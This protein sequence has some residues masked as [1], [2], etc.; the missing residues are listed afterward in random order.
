VCKALFIHG[1]ESEW[2]ES[3][4]EK[5]TDVTEGG[6]P[7]RINGGNGHEHEQGAASSMFGGRTPSIADAATTK[8]F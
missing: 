4:E 1:I 8:Y 5:Y 2:C 3:P 6:N 7:R